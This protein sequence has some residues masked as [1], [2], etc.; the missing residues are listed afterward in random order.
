MKE[1]KRLA[2]GIRKYIRREKTLIRKNSKDPEEE[3]R[4]TK[5][6]LS[7]FYKQK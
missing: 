2:K 1:R 3:K 5:E 7:R 6:L 4:L